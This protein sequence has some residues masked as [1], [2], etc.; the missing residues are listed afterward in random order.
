MFSGA[1]LRACM[2]KKVHLNLHGQS[3]PDI[4]LL[5]P[6]ALAQGWEG[7]VGVKPLSHL[8]L[9]E[10]PLPPKAS[11]EKPSKVIIISGLKSGALA[12]FCHLGTV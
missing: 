7:L 5:I 12:R 1:F 6:A 8:T 10:L 11:T 2:R 4:L 9:L 3:P